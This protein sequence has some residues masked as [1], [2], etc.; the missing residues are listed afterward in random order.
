[1][2]DVIQVAGYKLHVSSPLWGDKEIEH[3][4]FEFWILFGI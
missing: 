2:W 1:M 3:L 4:G